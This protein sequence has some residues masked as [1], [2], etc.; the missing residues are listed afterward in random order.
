MILK[1]E[2]QKIATSKKLGI[3]I[4]EKDYIL[5]CYLMPTV[6]AEHLKLILQRCFTRLDPSISIKVYPIHYRLILK[7]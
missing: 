5:S 6:G 2:I 3:D 4:V 1:E 7:A